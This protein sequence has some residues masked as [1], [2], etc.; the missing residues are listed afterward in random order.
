MKDNKNSFNCRNSG[1]RRDPKGQYFIGLILLIVGGL[2]FARNMIPDFPRW[3]FSWPMILIG[4][5][6][7]SGLRHGFRHPGSWILMLIGG[8][9]LADRLSDDIYL[10]PYFWP[11]L[12]VIGGA[13]FLL[14]PKR[15]WNRNTD[16]DPGS[17][18][19]D[20]NNPG[21]GFTP[22]SSTS[23]ADSNWSNDTTMQADVLDIT[24]IFGGVKKRVLSKHFSGGEIV[25]VFGG[26]EVNL[27]Q[28]DFSGKIRIEV[29][30]MF[31]G[32]K[33]IVPADWNVQS[34]VV[35]IMGGVD[36]KRPPANN[37]DPN[38]IIV[39]EGTCIMGGLEI[40]SF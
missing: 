26:C 9:F 5:G 19:P 23:P 28:S 20:I 33:L 34:E 2:L 22:G 7:F 12:F 29:F 25:A 24:A 14:K 3:V 37:F 36:D 18:K 17:D 4:I 1:R 35:A 39:L 21:S 40:K 27:L 11:I 30:N 8:I 16:Y 31:G 15:P 38:K 13:Y 6:I 32:T 10:R